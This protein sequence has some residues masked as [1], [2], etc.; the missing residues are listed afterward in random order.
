MER[1][2]RIRWAITFKNNYVFIVLALIVMGFSVV[3]TNFLHKDNLVNIL[4]M[5]VPILLVSSVATLVM[6]S[7]NIDLSVGSIVG[8]SGVIYCILLKN[9]FGFGW[10]TALTLAMG[11]LLGYINGLLVMKW[12]VVPV[13]ATLATMYLYRGLAW[14]LTPRQVGLIKGNLPAQINNFARSP[15][16]LDLPAAFYVAVG[17]ILM[18]AIIQ[19]KTTLGKYTAAIGGNRTAAELSGINVVRVVWILYIIVGFYAALGGIARA[20]YLSMG[21]PITGTGME[22]ETLIAILLGG[23]NFYGG[24]G[25]VLKTVVGA[26]ILMCVTVGMMVLWIPPFWQS[27]AKGAVLIAT[28][29]VYTLIKAKVG[30]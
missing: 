13:I 27:L 1:Q 17:A 22:S 19:K 15:V 8:L 5:S 11:I 20:S 18:I 29:A 9:G 4:R 28:V 14:T 26:L 24:E 12:R 2:R 30:E 3:S 25:S 16:F 21:D 6:V 7:G 23:T 10:S